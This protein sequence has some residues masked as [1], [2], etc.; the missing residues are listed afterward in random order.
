MRQQKAMV[1]RLPDD[2]ALSHQPL[3]LRYV[4]EIPPC[5]EAEPPKVS[6]HSATP[7]ARLATAHAASGH[8]GTSPGFY[9]SGQG[10]LFGTSWDESGPVVDSRGGDHVVAGNPSPAGR[11]RYYVRQHGAK[12]FSHTTIAYQPTDPAVIATEAT[13]MSQPMKN[14]ANKAAKTTT[15]IPTNCPRVMVAVSR[16]RERLRRVFMSP[17]ERRAGS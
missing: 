17:S 7:N 1:E 6:T 8:H 5:P 4:T 9:V 15:E 12:K 16:K 10:R 13:K 2:I 14:S 11:Y 3:A